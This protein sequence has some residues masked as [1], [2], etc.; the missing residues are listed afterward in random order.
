MEHQK[1][2]WQKEIQEPQNAE[3]LTSNI[4]QNAR[5]IIIKA[6]YLLED[7]IS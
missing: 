5:S 3:K 4:Y 7:K 1:H 2:Q 6:I